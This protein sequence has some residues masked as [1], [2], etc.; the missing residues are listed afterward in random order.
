VSDSQPEVLTRTIE[1]LWPTAEVQVTRQAPGQAQACW[2]LLPAARRPRLLVPAGNPGASVMLRRYS[3][4]R[5]AAPARTVIEAAVRT[6][7]IERLPVQRVVVNG[8]GVH[9]YLSDALCD[10]AAVGV[11]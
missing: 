8:G 10:M 3:G 6:G 11:L 7:A 1:Q 9:V 5:W 4:R 2:L